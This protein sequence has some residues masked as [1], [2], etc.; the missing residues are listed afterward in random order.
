MKKQAE[1]QQQ[2]GHQDDG[3]A[4]GG[5]HHRDERRPARRRLLDRQPGQQARMLR[6]GPAADDRRHGECRGDA[7]RT[8]T[9]RPDARD[10]HEPASGGG[11][12]HGET[13]SAREAVEERPSIVA[14]DQEAREGERA[15]HDRGEQRT[16]PKIVL[17]CRLAES[18][19]IGGEVDGAQI[20]RRR[21]RERTDEDGGRIQPARDEVASRVADGDTTGGDGADDG[22]EGEGR[23]DRR[24]REDPLDGSLRWLSVELP[25]QG[26]GRPTQDDADRGDEQRHGERGHDRA[27]GDRIGGPADDED[28][29]QPDVIRLPDG[30]H[31]VPCMVARRR[32]TRAS[33]A[34]E[35]DPEAGAEVRT[36]EHGVS[37][38]ADEDQDD[39]DLSEHASAPARA[40]HG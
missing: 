23:Q 28:E 2:R 31:R 14:N 5:D 17:E 30:A 20:A 24:E 4:G 16:R 21:D 36:R 6:D 37:G 38:E 35:Q 19:R 26:V 33:T 3:A 39:R 11:A 15:G 29:D 22:A 27:E 10:G 7:R 18:L 9:T 12:Y 32:R 13:G 1:E 25:P 8:E 40:A 34:G